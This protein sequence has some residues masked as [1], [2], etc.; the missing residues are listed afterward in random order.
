MATNENPSN[1]TTTAQSSTSVASQP[2]DI[3][4]TTANTVLPL[5]LPLFDPHNVRDWVE[6][7]QCQFRL[8]RIF[9]DEEQFLHAYPS[10]PAAVTGILPPDTVHQ[11][12]FSVLT[13]RLIQVYEPSE[14]DKFQRLTSEIHLDGK[15]SLYLQRLSQ[16]GNAC[17]VGEAYIRNRFLHGLPPALA[18]HLATQTGPLSE[19]GVRADILYQFLHPHNVSSPSFPSPLSSTPSAPSFNSLPPFS[20]SSSHL[21]PAVPS[22]TSPPSSHSLLS[23]HSSPSTLAPHPPIS[24]FASA[25][26]ALPPTASLPYFPPF[27]HSSQASSY[28][29]TFPPLPPPSQPPNASSPQLSPYTSY[30]SP[31]PHFPYFPQPY[32]AAVSPS[33]PCHAYS[34]GTLDAL[35]PFS[36]GQRPRVCRFHIFFGAQARRC[37]P[38]CSW[39]FK[40]NVE[41]LPSSRPASPASSRPG[42]PSGNA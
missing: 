21:S 33:R 5:R 41:I 1:V 20:A 18:M 27:P 42:S 32:V 36:P 6:K 38:W 28:T 14:F 30:T 23:P 40:D 12:K 16:L 19:L 39:P 3:L 26:Q 7:V 24:H 15:P 35:R 37:K 4:I 2:A 11:G 29:S 13:E 9:E 17:N 22:F 25:A 8:A 31:T 34:A 10:L